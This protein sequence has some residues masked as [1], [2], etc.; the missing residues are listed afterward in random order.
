[1]NKGRLLRIVAAGA[2]VGT[3][4]TTLGGQPAGAETVLV[5]CSGIHSII[6]LNPAT[7]SGDA[8]YTKWG[9]TDSNGTKLDLFGAPIPP[10]AQSCTV[11]PG[12]STNQPAPQDVRYTLDNQTNGAATLTTAG[13]LAKSTI[14]VSG[15]GTC[16]QGDP[17]LNTAYPASYPL[18]GKVVTKF[19]QLS[20]TGAQIQM[21]SYVRFGA[22]PDD[23][24]VTVTGIVMKGPGLGG[25]VKATLSIFPTNSVKNLNA[26]DC[27]APSGSSAG[28]AAIAEMSLAQSD[29]PDVGTAIDPWEVTIP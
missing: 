15:S 4:L 23:G 24:D 5:S 6:T 11:D 17:L 1:M 19:D 29:G 14:S 10:D 16:R 26:V 28:D 2:M 12:I 8:R 20:L 18:Q 21:Q 7:G 9:T 25:T 3:G 27:I 22:D 13:L